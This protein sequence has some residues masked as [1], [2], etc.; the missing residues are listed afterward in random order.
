MGFTIPEI[1]T[2]VPHNAQ[3]ETQSCVGMLNFIG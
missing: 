2:P 1:K 3:S